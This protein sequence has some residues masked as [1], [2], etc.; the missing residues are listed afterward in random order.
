MCLWTKWENNKKNCERI[1]WHITLPHHRVFYITYTFPSAITFLITYYL[2]DIIFRPLH[3]ICSMHIVP[4]WKFEEKKKREKTKSCRKKSLTH[5]LVAEKKKQ[6][7]LSIM[8]SVSVQPT[9][10]K[11]QAR[12]KRREEKK[13]RLFSNYYDNQRFNW[14]S[15]EAEHWSLF[16]S[17]INKCAHFTCS[18]KNWKMKR[19]GSTTQK[20]I[21][22]NYVQE[23]L[24]G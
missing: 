14:N 22:I 4:C 5:T 11:C 19:M 17:W 12:T 1:I 2:C 23:K 24:Y 8:S 18:E 16:V 13:Y 6:F 7:A 15:Y 3:D 21:E 9:K 20:K 10:I